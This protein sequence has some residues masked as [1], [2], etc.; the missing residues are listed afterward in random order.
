MYGRHAKMV[1]CNVLGAHLT[2][3]KGMLYFNCNLTVAK[4][5]FFEWKDENKTILTVRLVKGQKFFLARK[6]KSVVGKSFRFSF[7]LYSFL[8][9]VLLRNA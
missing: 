8:F 2:H 9:S 7:V 6:S 3:L 1:F 4:H 5:D